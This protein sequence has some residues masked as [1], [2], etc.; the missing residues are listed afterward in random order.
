MRGHPRGVSAVVGTVVLIALVTVL[1][2]GVLAAG[3]AME[4]LANPPPTVVSDGASVTA[5]CPGCGSADQVIRLRHRSGDD[6]PMD[7]VAVEVA[8]PDS[9]QTGRLV[10]LPLSG[11]CLRDSHVEGTDLFDGRCGRVAGSLTAVGE[12]SDGVWQA[13]ETLSVR[14]KKSAVRLVPGDV[15]TV[16]VWHTP[17]NTVVTSERLS[18]V[19]S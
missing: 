2:T 15:V 11:N 7:G 13:G 5:A 16:T 19:G 6:V 9:D 14:L 17:T 10:D 3:T 18:V 8:V 12:T 4:S 1:A